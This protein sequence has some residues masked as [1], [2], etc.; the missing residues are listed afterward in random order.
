MTID[1][2]I[3]GIKNDL[4]VPLRLR[5]NYFYEDLKKLR[6]LKSNLSVEV[7]YK[8]HSL[9]FQTAC[10]DSDYNRAET[11]QDGPGSR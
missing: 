11:H 9:N 5:S 8:S 6:A 7:I 10:I 2:K 3:I 4:W 1:F